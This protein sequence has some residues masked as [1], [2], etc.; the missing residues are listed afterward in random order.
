MKIRS[1]C[2]RDCYG[3]CSVIL[4]VE[5]DRIV[6]IEGDPLNKATQGYICLK[7]K[8]YIEKNYGDKRLKFPLK[9]VG[10]RGE[11]RFIRVSWEE[12]I[13]EISKKLVYYQHV[14]PKSVMFY[15]G[16]GEIGTFSKCASG[17]W[18]QLKGYT[19]T[20]GDL[21]FS[22]GLEGV[23][24]T[25]GKAIHNAPWDLENAKCI[26]LWGKNSAETNFQEMFFIKKARNNGAKVIV[27]DPVKTKTAKEADYFL[28]I[29][30]GQ[31]QVLALGLA[32][33]LIQNKMID[34]EFIDKYT[35]GFEEFK[36][37][38][39]KFDL[40]TVASICRIKEDDIIKLARLIWDNRPLSLICGLGLQ[41]RING[42]QTV[43]AIGLIPAL[44]GSIG[45]KGGGFRYANLSEPKLQWPFFIDAPDDVDYV[46]V[47]EIGKGIIEKNIKMLFVQSANPV[48]SN[49]DSKNI[50]KALTELDFI[51]IIEQY[52]SDTAKFADY[53]LPA[54]ATFEYFDLLKSYWHPYVI[55]MDKAH[56][57]I[58]ECKHESEIYR[59]LAEKLKLNLDHIPENNLDN[60]EKILKASG[61]EIA[62][63][64]L[65]KAPYLPKD[66]DEVA[67]RDRKFNTVTGKIQFKSKTMKKWKQSLLPEY[68]ENEKTDYPLM[69]ISYHSYEKI[70]SQYSEID[71]IKKLMGAPKAKINPEDARVRNII[72]GD[73]VKIFNYMGAI[74]A[75]AEVTN[76]IKQGLISIPFGLSLEE[77]ANVNDVVESMKTD[78]GNGTAFH[79][80]YVDVI[81]ID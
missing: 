10:E 1:G 69:L 63:E 52:L 70:N 14:N 65:K 50:R 25:Y 36:N 16:S 33:Y 15:K 34:K 81:K 11:G 71:K 56:D 59:M 18:N 75:Y 4:T 2:P 73:R 47:S 62:L 78:I 31:D 19:T 37:Y 42:G 35:Y 8:S 58:F 41:R 24:Q 68:K 40:K 76:D 17:F 49:P 64:D 32:N 57:P 66:Y 53:I 39:E 54:A 77:K 61:I 22:A 3:G 23:I 72:S 45:I 26:I 7:G 74:F 48:V 51:V 5:N 43:R 29:M 28:Q 30:P 67:F 13:E 27:I 38:V 60:V 55:F 9:R 80:N 44:V 6:N 79:D 21:C 12:A 20:Y 46:H